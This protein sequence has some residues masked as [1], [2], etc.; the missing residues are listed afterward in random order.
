MKYRKKPVVI[1]AVQYLRE[2]NISSCIDFCSEMC[3]EPIDNEY[4]I[5]TLEGNMKVSK[6]DYIIKGVNGEF[7]PCKPDIF[8][9][10]Y[11]LL[12]GKDE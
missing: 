3:Y 5:K 4:Y 7:Y 12:E 11:D 9:K 6:G 2:E 1:E 10:T 8:E